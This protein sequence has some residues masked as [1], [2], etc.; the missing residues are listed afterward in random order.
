MTDPGDRQDATPAGA[1]VAEVAARLGVTPDAVRRRLHRGTLAGAKTADGEWRVWFPDDPPG[2]RQDDRQDDRQDTARTRQDA[3]PA[4][5]EGLRAHV[6]D[7]RDEVA[8]L[9]EQLAQ[10]SR[11]LA[12]ERERFDVLHREALGRIPALGAGSVPEEPLSAPP[13]APESPP[14]AKSKGGLRG[15]LR[16][17]WG[18]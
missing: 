2:P 8:F 15:L 5:A 7:L 10:R 1:T 9:R 18:G 6:D 4:E 14:A 13:A 17:L 12:A 3:T 11:E 16:R